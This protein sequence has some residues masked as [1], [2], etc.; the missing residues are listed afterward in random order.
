MGGGKGKREGIGSK[1]GRN[2]GGGRE[3]EKKVRGKGIGLGKEGER[4]EEG[5]RVEGK[6]EGRQNDRTEWRRK[7]ISEDY[8]GEL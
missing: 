1:D 7:E 5:R 6:E 8:P 2:K 3:G 4:W